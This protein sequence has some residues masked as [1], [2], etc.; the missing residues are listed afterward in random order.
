MKKLYILILIL[1]MF[2]PVLVNAE[3]VQTGKF[4]YMPAFEDE[5]EE[6][7][8]YSDDYFKETGKE[9]NEHLLGMS[10]NLSLSTFEIRDYSYSKDLLEEIGYNKFKAYDMKEKPTLDTIGMVI[11]TKK[12]GKNN[13]IAVALRGEKYDSEWGNNFIVGKS[14]NAKGFNDSS[15]KVINRIKKYIEDNNLKNNKIWITGYSRAGAIADLTGVYINNHLNEFKTTADDLY[16]YT[17]EP[18]AA[19]IDDTV[20]DNIYTVINKNDLIPQVYPKTWGFY[21]NGKIIS[22]GDNQTITT[23]KGLLSQEEIGSV[24]TNAFLNDFFTWLPSRLSRD[25]YAT[26]LEQPIS[27]IMDIYFSKNEEDR[28]KLMAFLTNEVKTEVIDTCSTVFLD[29]FERNSDSIYKNL[30]KEVIKAIENV[31]NSE[32]A[33]VLTSDELQT[34]KNSIYYILKALGPIIV[35]DYYYFDGIDYD[36]Y[37]A[38][39]YPQFVLDENEYAYI[40][41]KEQGF[42]RGYSDAQYDGPRDNTVPD[43]MFQEDDTEKYIANFTR[44]YQETY[45]DGYDLGLSHKNDIEAKGKYDGIEAGKE[46]GS[47][48]GANGKPNSPNPDDY[49]TVPDW[50]GTWTECDDEDEYCESTI[51]YSEVDLENIEKYKTNYYEGF[52]EG[53]NEG[54]SEGQNDGPN[55]GMELSMYHFATLL[56]NVSTLMTNHHPQ[57]NLKLIHALDS[58]YAPYDLIEGANQTAITDDGEKDS[59]TFKTSG[60]LEKLIEVQV[61]GKKL[62]KSDYELKSGSTIVTLK[63]SFLK[64]LKEGIHTLKLIYIDNTIETT[65]K[66]ENKSSNIQPKNNNINGNEISPP[67]TNSKSISNLIKNNL[68]SKNNFIIYIILFVL[69]IVVTIKTTFYIKTIK[70]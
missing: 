57:E 12:V 22:I 36:T 62:N 66:I 56:K 35:D 70:I 60:H 42:S 63:N 25:E 30:S 3:S 43:W 51:E 53:W 27:K 64:T 55:R 47:R 14:G 6:V 29:I 39:Y 13:I 2:I 5:T 67:K 4:K 33:K 10:Y 31:E 69:T 24:D 52:I 7:Y 44:G 16:I 15:V 23:Y 37:Y 17:F 8:Y 54:Y 40:N 18:P 68:T 50:I 41:G 32:N 65:F 59:L 9:Y 61:D 19:S 21:T 48:A 45:D 1:F 58:Y 34:I 11:A 46:I 20:Y 49:Y 26:D 28:A 38:K